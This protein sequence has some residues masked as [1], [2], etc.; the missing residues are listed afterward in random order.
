MYKKQRSLCKDYSAF[1]QK[2][3][4]YGQGEKQEEKNMYY[5]VGSLA[6]AA[7]AMV[8]V[9]K[10]IDYMA[11]QFNNVKPQDNDDDWGPEILSKEKPKKEDSDGEL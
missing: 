11:D 10:V 2:G 6:L 3:N 4:G 7:G 9:P 1:V 5:V 8:I